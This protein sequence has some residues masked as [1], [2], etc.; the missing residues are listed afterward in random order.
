[1]RVQARNDKLWFALLFLLPFIFVLF[2]FGAFSHGA[3]REGI[4]I[5]A[6][7]DLFPSL[8]AADLNIQDKTGRDGKLHLVLAHADIP[9]KAKEFAAH[10]ASV[11]RIRGVSIRVVIADYQSL[12]QFTDQ[13]IAGVF[14]IQPLTHTLKPII[15]FAREHQ[16][17]L[18]SP[19]EGD[20]E[21]GVSGGMHI[22]DR[23]LP[24]LNISALEA[25][26]IRIKSFFLRVSVRYAE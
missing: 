2:Q 7:L 9:E 10:L 21:R 19:F 24:Y 8:L 17:I 11:E 18:F 12:D 13:T 1:M 25:A 22:S 14:L 20:V 23:V 15:T 16:C 26:N 3:E 6:G 4:R 5:R